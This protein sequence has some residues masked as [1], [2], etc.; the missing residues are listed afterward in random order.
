MPCTVY[1][2]FINYCLESCQP[3]SSLNTVILL[4]LVLFILL[5]K[6]CLF[7]RQPGR[8]VRGDVG[9]EPTLKP[10]SAAFLIFK[11][12]FCQSKASVLLTF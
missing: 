5:G 2:Q 10:E 4:S 12:Y 9:R 6:A 7:S 8:L 11:I 1:T 3:L